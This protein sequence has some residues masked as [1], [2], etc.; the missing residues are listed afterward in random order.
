[1]LLCTIAKAFLLRFILVNESEKYEKKSL[2][3]SE[4]KIENIRMSSPR[5]VYYRLKKKKKKKKKND[6]VNKINSLKNTDIRC[7][8]RV[9]ATKLCLFLLINISYQYSL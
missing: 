1:M 9:N 4:A 2:K 7:A 8:F 6:K 3:I 5:Y